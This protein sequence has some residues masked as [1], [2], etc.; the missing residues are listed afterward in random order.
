MTGLLP[1]AAQTGQ[2]AR[3]SRAKYFSA[4][5][6]EA[7]AT[8]LGLFHRYAYILRPIAGG[9]WFSAQ[10]NWSLSDTEI[11]KAAACAHPNYY[12][13]TRCG[14]A[15][16][17][18]VLDIDNGSPYHNEAGFL[19]ISALLNKAG[20]EGFNL[21]RSSDSGGWHIYIFFDAP[22]SSRD[23]YRQLHKL[24][25]LHDFEVAKGKLEL[26]P[27]PG[28][29][30]LGQG[31]RL[32]LQPGFAWL[33]EHNQQVR[34][35][36][37]EIGPA[38][39]VLQFAKDIECTVNPYHHFH[40]LRAF[41]EGVEA[42]KAEIVM[43]ANTKLPRSEVVLLRPETPVQGCEEAQKLVKQIFHKLPPG[44]NCESYLRG[45]HYYEHGLTGASQR[46]DATFTMGHYLFYGDPERLIKPRGYGFEDERMWLIEE[47]FKAKH[48]G[49]SKDI[50][51]GREEA[52][53]HI[54]RAT[55][56]QPPQ[57]RGREAQKYEPV[58]PISWVRN[59]ANRATKAQKKIIAA[60]EDFREA[61]MPFSTRDLSLKSG[62][63]SRTIAKYPQLWKQAMEDI[64]TGRLASALH[65]YNAV[66]GA[67]SQES[68]PPSSSDQKNMHPGR[69]A[70]RRIVYELKMRT[71][72]EQRQKLDLVRSSE[73]D[74]SDNWRDRVDQLV[75]KE[76]HMTSEDALRNLIKCLSRELL[77][78]PTEEECTW[79]SRY[80]SVIKNRVLE[81]GQPIQ[82][83]LEPIASAC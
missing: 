65:E 27:N 16:K 4:R 10:D 14:K 45:R 41:V 62:V 53:K 49:M 6:E 35:E 22:V 28:D 73:K 54:E 32:P 74:S 83:T 44:I 55:H 82:L 76:V 23:M 47:I 57:R 64:R 59:N 19:K 9:P 38:E 42:T 36:R 52:Q 20:I 18:A 34:E 58:V 26:F 70:A 60:V 77:I 61:E 78:A 75:L 12:L 66:E 30:S 48:H 67:T 51:S 29:K 68:Q 33:N 11:L 2:P 31:L 69:L 80:I 15:T 1:L 56:W 37:D 39:A 43:Q 5:T 8:F 25:S 71:L 7:V 24:F 17:Y 46:A 72:R 79:L 13:G 21:Y 81:I 40:K 63:S 50:A 3:F